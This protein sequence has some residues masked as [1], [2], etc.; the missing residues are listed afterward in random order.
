MLSGARGGMVGGNDEKW[1]G[2]I[3]DVDENWSRTY[4]TPKLILMAII[5]FSR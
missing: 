4:M 3:E 2:K 5:I 1:M